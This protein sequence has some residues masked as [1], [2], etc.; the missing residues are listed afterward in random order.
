MRACARM[1]VDVCVWMC[2]C[3]V[4]HINIPLLFNVKLSFQK[5]IIVSI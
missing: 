1:C 3:G 4:W 2:S 5:D